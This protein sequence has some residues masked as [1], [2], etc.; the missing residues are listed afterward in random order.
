MSTLIGLTVNLG[1][2]L[3][4]YS[5]MAFFLT[6]MYWRGHGSLAVV[7]TI[8]VAEV[9]WILPTTLAFPHAMVGPFVSYSF[10]FGN[11]LVSGFAIVLFCQTVKNIPRQL[12]DSARLDGC[13][14]FGTYWHVVLPL[15]RRDLG[16]IAV[17]IIMAS[18]LVWAADITPRGGTDFYPFFPFLHLLS[19]DVPTNMLILSA[20]TTLPVV[21]IFFVAKR[22]LRTP[23][24]STFISSENAK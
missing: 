16:F 13:G 17:L 6:R 21:A 20:I 18:W 24:L 10:C 22:Q 7:M 23:A 1:G 5:F 11:W 3:V 2:T 15:I 9:F 8:I 4:I 12:G 14:W 19:D